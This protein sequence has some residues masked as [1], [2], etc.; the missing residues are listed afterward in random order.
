MTVSL[1]RS[2]IPRLP[3]HITRPQAH[4]QAGGSQHSVL[5][6]HNLQELHHFSR[7]HATPSTTGVYPAM[8]ELLTQVTH[9][10]GRMHTFNGLVTVKPPQW[11]YNRSLFTVLETDVRR[12]GNSALSTAGGLQ[13][14]P[15]SLYKVFS[16]CR[17]KEFWGYRTK[18]P[19]HCFGN[20][21]FPLLSLWKFICVVHR[22]L[23]C[24]GNDGDPNYIRETSNVVD[25]SLWTY[26]GRGL[27]HPLSWAFQSECRHFIQESSNWDTRARHWGR[28]TCRCLWSAYTLPAS[29]HFN[30]IPLQ[31]KL[32]AKLKS[33]RKAWNFLRSSSSCSSRSYPRTIDRLDE[34]LFRK[35]C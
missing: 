25:K 24:Q 35:S 29:Y 30:W 3:G 2:W 18:E 23:G 17:R 21:L 28:V 13:T 22:L 1:R 32:R 20:Y 33:K 12:E 16:Y 15:R 10:P 14:A 6:S 8:L 27:Y 31:W 4:S 9:C 7:T 26:S 11:P 19:C 5:I 34:L